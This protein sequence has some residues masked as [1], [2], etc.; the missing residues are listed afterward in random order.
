[1]STGRSSPTIDSPSMHAGG[2]MWLRIEYLR[3]GYD[4]D[5]RARPQIVG[6]SGYLGPRQFGSRLWLIDTPVASDDLGR[7]RGGVAALVIHDDGVTFRLEV[8]EA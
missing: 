2:I 1:M 5:S 8:V 4:D 3:E 7:A 6:H